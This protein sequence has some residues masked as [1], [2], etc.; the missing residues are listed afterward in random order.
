M[1]PSGPPWRFLPSAILCTVTVS[2]TYVPLH[3]RR[4]AEE[5]LL[6]RAVPVGVVLQ[7]K[8]GNESAGH[9]FH[10]GVWMQSAWHWKSKVDRFGLSGAFYYLMPQETMGPD[11]GGRRGIMLFLP[12]LVPAGR[13]GMNVARNSPGSLIATWPP[14]RGCIRPA[15]PSIL[16]ISPLRSALFI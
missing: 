5:E 8:S 16:A 2:A 7:W 1:S 15:R 12:P 13:R 11:A 4:R 14:A 10:I 9:P 3:N 6:R